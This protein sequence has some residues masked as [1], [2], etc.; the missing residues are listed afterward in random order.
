[1]SIGLVCILMSLLTNILCCKTLNTMYQG[2][3]LVPTSS[4]NMSVKLSRVATS[5]YDELVSGERTRERER[6]GEIL[7]LREREIERK[8][9]RKK[10][11]DRKREREK[12]HEKGRESKLKRKIFQV[13][14][15]ER[16][17]ERKIE[18]DQES[19]KDQERDR[20]ILGS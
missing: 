7:R 5:I 15:Q 16:E 19:E 20:K 2:S 9:E 4:Y 13:R 17:R 18:K 6:L 1:M 12:T 14:D 8:R 10:E 3:S 11:K